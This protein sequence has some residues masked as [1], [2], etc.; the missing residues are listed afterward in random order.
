MRNFEH[1]PHST[2]T[3][4]HCTPDVMCST[5]RRGPGTPLRP[6]TPKGRAHGESRELSTSAFRRVSP[7]LFTALACCT[8]WANAQSSVT[9]YGVAD[10]GFGRIV[11]GD[12][13]R[14][15]MLSGVANGSRLGFRGQEDLG[16]GMNA[17][18]V[19]ETGMSLNTGAFTQGGLAFGRQIFV[20]L[21]SKEGWSISAGRQLSPLALSMIA[22]D[23]LGWQ[24]FGNTLGTGLTVHESAGETPASGGFQATGR[25]N[26]SV[27]GA[28][29]VE[30]LSF[31]GMFGAGNEDPR[32]S[33][34]L[35]SGSVTYND[36]ALLL[37]GALV[38]FR[39]YAGGIA[40]TADPKWQSQYLLGASYDFKVA[41]IS[42]GYYVFDAETAG[43]NPGQPVGLD[44]RFDR[45][46]TAWLGARVPVGSGAILFNTML[47]KLDYQQRTD[48]KG[49][50]FGVA[51]EH[52]LSKR[53]AL[54]ASYGQ[55]NNNATGLTSLFSAIPAVIPNAQGAELRA[56]ALG[57]RHTF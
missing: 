4:R 56:Y 25:V 9:I 5:E 40:P 45:S 14:I 57:V 24:Y 11:N 34:R 19:L 10:A 20:G 39:Q 13:K 33:G 54:Y 1:R 16:G 32:G 35:F 47:S 49:V 26:N 31:M 43:R 50:T 2:N 51:Y 27:L 53:T 3:E 38:R 18:F 46:K 6:S 17:N 30:R 8:G 12:V 55:V 21:S 23:P 44:P 52:S 28:Y 48:G 37:T 29:K 42:A 41:K 36:G 15:Q 22:S 7:A